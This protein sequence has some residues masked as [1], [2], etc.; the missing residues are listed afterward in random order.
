M[1]EQTPQDLRM[2][3]LFFI[4][5][6]TFCIRVLRQNIMTIQ[7]LLRQVKTTLGVRAGYAIGVGSSGTAAKFF[8]VGGANFGRSPQ[9]G[10]QNVAIDP[11]RATFAGW[12]L[13]SPTAGVYNSFG[14][15]PI[16]NTAPGRGQANAVDA[17]R[18]GRGEIEFTGGAP[19]GTLF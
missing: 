3:H 19:A 15:L 11:S 4:S 17:I 14:F 10:W 18:W 13:G 12:T 2:A 6:G 8:H 9:G 16:V 5:G 7:Q 1:R